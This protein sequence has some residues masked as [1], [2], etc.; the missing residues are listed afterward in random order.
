MVTRQRQIKTRQSGRI[1]ELM[2][3]C[4]PTISATCSEL[5]T[6]THSVMLALFLPPDVIADTLMSDRI[7]LTTPPAVVATIGARLST[8][9]ALPPPPHVD[10]DD[11]DVGMAPLEADTAVSVATPMFRFDANLARSNAS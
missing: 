2:I 9:D 3:P 10:D 4:L 11:I 6:G 7:L 8:G 5:G 1:H